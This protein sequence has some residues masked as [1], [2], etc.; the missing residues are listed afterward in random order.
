M[1]GSG[2]IRIAPFDIPK[3]VK[4]KKVK[5]GTVLTPLLKEAN[6]QRTKGKALSEAH[7]AKISK[8]VR[9]ALARKR[10]DNPDGMITGNH[11]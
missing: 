2:A 9:E 8:A 4:V 7:R 10:Q 6:R 5:L 11:P 1:T 3:G